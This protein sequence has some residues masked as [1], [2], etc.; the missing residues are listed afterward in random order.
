MRSATCS[1]TPPPEELPESDSDSSSDS[2]SSS[3]GGGVGPGE[4]N[5]TLGVTCAAGSFCDYPD[6]LCGTG[7]NGVCTP[8][9]GICPAIF[10]PHCG[11]DN[12]TH[13]NECVANGNGTDI[14][15]PGPC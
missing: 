6:D 14:A 10:D 13:S 1:S 8:A 2:G 9:G 4:C 11:C 3:G 12:V 15:S 7:A 5:E